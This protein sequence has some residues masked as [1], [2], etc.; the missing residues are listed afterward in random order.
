MK[1]KTY[2]KINLIVILSLCDKPL[3]LK[4]EELEVLFGLLGLLGGG[5][6]SN[7]WKKWKN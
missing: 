4:D 2:N 1:I 6:F 7:L 3:L 5:L